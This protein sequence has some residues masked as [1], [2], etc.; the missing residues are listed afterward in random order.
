MNYK[1][2]IIEEFLMKEF[3][4]QHQNIREITSLTF[5]KV[6]FFINLETFVLGAIITIFSLGIREIIY[7]FFILTGFLSLLGHTI[8]M[9]TVHSIAQEIALDFVNNLIRF[10]FKRNYS[11]ETA[12]KYIYFAK[13]FEKI[14]HIDTASAHTISKWKHHKDPSTFISI[15][16][17][18]INSFNIAITIIGIFMFILRS[19]RINSDIYILLMGAVFTLFVRKIYFAIFF[20]KNLD[21]IQAQ[22]MKEWTNYLK[23]ENII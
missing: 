5:Q 9:T 12:S 10:Y 17:G 1:S 21:Q 23:S 3:E 19:F 15:F 7:Y 22:I 16:V 2:T 18:N 8:F 13:D 4:Q 14:Y 6:Q 20:D 11:N